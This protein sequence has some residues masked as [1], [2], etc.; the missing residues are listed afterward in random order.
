MSVRE[1]NHVFWENHKRYK[2]EILVFKV[3]IWGHSTTMWTKFYPI[4]TTPRVENCGHFTYYLPFVYETKDGLIP[5]PHSCPRSYWMTPMDLAYFAFAVHLV[6]C[7]RMVFLNLDE[8][9]ERCRD[10]I[11]TLLWLEA[12]LLRFGGHRRKCPMTNIVSDKVRLSSTSR[13]TRKPFIY[14]VSIFFSAFGPPSTLCEHIFSTELVSKNSNFLTPL[15]PSSAYVI[16]ECY[17]GSSWYTPP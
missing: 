11:E 9:G 12:L 1:K 3:H 13:G 17:L 4:S 5:P 6:H 7:L 15:S 8:K 14:Y 2:T 16:Y 10:C